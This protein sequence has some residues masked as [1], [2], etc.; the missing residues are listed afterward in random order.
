MR[1]SDE[2]VKFSSAIRAICFR[3]ETNSRVKNT[4][5]AVFFTLSSFLHTFLVFS[6]RLSVCR[7]YVSV[8]LNLSISQICNARELVHLR[9]ICE[10]QN[11]KTHCA[12]DAKHLDFGVIISQIPSFSN[13]NHNIIV[14]CR[15]HKLFQHIS[16]LQP[17]A[18]C[19]YA[20]MTS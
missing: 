12:T 11:L 5:S 1:R 17:Q 14:P 13:M 6:Q 15:R 19:I 4:A 18:G 3:S 10:R 8:S 16:G 9:K 7:T 2:N 20:W